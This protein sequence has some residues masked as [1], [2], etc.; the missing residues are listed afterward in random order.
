MPLRS[1]AIL[2]PSV[3]VL[4]WATGFVVARLVT[5]F[6]D[7]LLFLTLRFALAA[8]VLSLLAFAA[9]APWPSTPRAWADAIVAGILL[10]GIYLG[11]VFWAIS[12]GLPAG[13]SALIAGTQPLI[14]AALAGPLLKERVSPQR[15]AGVALGCV[16]IVLVLAPKLGLDGYSP[17]ALAASF[18]SVAG[19][20]AATFW[21]KRTGNGAD[22]RSG[23]AVQF[24]GATAVVLVGS[25]LTEPMRIEPHPALWFGLAW[26]TL[27]MSVGAIAL[28]LVMIR[29]GAVVAVSSLLFLVPPVSA[30]MAYGLFGESL[31]VIQIV[32]MGLAA[33]GTALA[34]RE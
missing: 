25:V 23:T 16:G 3:F 26:A 12:K 10:H 34:A 17:A 6:I 1:S 4:S 32:G 33:V 5:P 11:G 7:P 15:W 9:R 21:Q 13:I 18:I 28:L 24:M 20:T 2:I 27:A 14:A 31:T 29:R 8:L 30:L 19:I 22:L